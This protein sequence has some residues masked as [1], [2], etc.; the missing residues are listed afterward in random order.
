M[1]TNINFENILGNQANMGIVISKP[2]CT[3]TDA[4]AFL[5]A[6]AIT[7]RTITNAICSLVVG[8]KADGIWSKFTAIYPFVGGTASTHKWNL[9]D[10]RDLN[11]AYRLTFNGGWTHDSQ[12]VK[13]NGTNTYADT[14]FTGTLGMI[15]VYMPRDGGPA[16]GYT[17][18]QEYCD[19]G[20]YVNQQQVCNLY[21]NSAQFSSYANYYAYGYFGE[22]LGQIGSTTGYKNGVVISGANGS[23]PVINLP[24]GAIRA[25][26]YDIYGSIYYNEVYAFNNEVQSFS[27]F[28]TVE[29][30]ATESANLYT[31]V[32]A[33]QTA[34]GRQVANIPVS[35]PDAF[36]FL[37]NGGIRNPGT[38]LIQM[39]ALENLAI[40]LKTAN[41]WTKMRDIFPFLTD[42]RN[43]FS[44]SQD[45]ANAYW[46]KSNVAIIANST[47]APNN[48]TTASSFLETANPSNH[49]I[50]VS[51]GLTLSAEKY[52]TSIYLKKGT[53]DWAYISMFNVVTSDTF[54]GYFNL[55]TGTIGTVTSGATATIIDSGNGWYRCTLTRTMSTYNGTDAC[56]IGSASADNTPNYSGSG[57]AVAMYIWGAQL[58]FG[59]DA[60][61][62]QVITITSSIRIQS[63][64]GGNLKDQNAPLNGFQGGWTFSRTG[65]KGNGINGYVQPQRNFTGTFASGNVH[66]SIYSRVGIIPDRLM[67]LWGASIPFNPYGTLQA[68]FMNVAEQYYSPYNMQMSLGGFGAAT[69]QMLNTKGLIMTSATNAGT[70]GARTYQNGALRR[71]DFAGTGLP[72]NV[73]FNAYYDYNY[74]NSK[75]APFEIAFISTGLGLTEAEATTFNTIVANYQTALSRQADLSNVAPVN[76]AAPVLSGTPLVG[77]TLTSSTGTWT[78]AT[79]PN[80]YY[81]W[82]RNGG[83]D[84]GITTSTYVLTGSDFNTNITCKVT[85][86]SIDGFSSPVTSNSFLINQAATNTNTPFISGQQQVGSTLTATSGSWTG[87]TPITFAYQWKKNGSNIVG[88]TSTTYVLVAGDAGASTTIQCV[89][90]GTNS[91]GSGTGN[92]N[93][94]TNIAPAFPVN[95]I[96]PVISGTQRVGQ[97]LTTTNGTWTGIT[98]ITYT[99]QWK[100]NGSNI[101]SATAQTYTLVSGDFGTGTTIQCVVTGTNSFGN[102]T[103]NSN[104]LTGVG[105]ALPVV[106]DPN[107]QAFI[108]AADIPDVTQANAI[109][110]LVIG[111]KADNL[112]NSLDDIYPLVGGTAST[113]KWNLK[114]PTGNQLAFV[115]G[116]THDSNGITGNGINGF[117]YTNNFTARSYGVYSRTANPTGTFIGKQRYTSGEEETY[118]W[119]YS[120]LFSDGFQGGPY[121]VY[122]NFG[123]TA[124]YDNYYSIVGGDTGAVNE[125]KLYRK[126][127]NILPTAPGNLTPWY[128]DTPFAL[129]ATNIRYYFWWDTSQYGEYQSYVSNANIAFAHF[130]TTLLNAT[131]NANLYNRIKTFQQALG[132]AVFEADPDAQAFITAAAIT[133]TTQQTAVNNLVVGLKADGLWTKMKAIYPFVGGTASS[134]KFNLKD[135]RDLDAAF[136]LQFFGGVTHNA[137][138]MTGNGTNGYANT[139]VKLTDGVSALGIPRGA[140]HWSSYN[141]SLP[142]APSTGQQTGMVDANNTSNFFGWGVSVGQWYFG[143]QAF[144]ATGVTAATGFLMLYTENFSG[145]VYSYFNLNG[146]SL[147]NAGYGFSNNWSL[148]SPYFFLGTLGIPSGSPTFNNTN[149]AFVSLGDT[150]NTAGDITNFNTRVQAFQ[151]TLG[152]LALDADAQAFVTAANITNTTQIIAIDNLVRGLKVDGLWTK[153]AALYPFVGGTASSHKFNLKNPQ[154]TDGALRLQFF[155]GWTHDANGITGNGT[156]SYADTFARYSSNIYDGYPIKSE[157]NHWSTYQTTIGTIASSNGIQEPGFLFGFSTGY[158]TK[159]VGLQQYANT[160]LTESVAFWNGTVTSS[161]AGALYKNGTSVFTTSAAYG[162]SNNPTYV[163]GASRFN[164][165]ISGSNN[166]RFAF[167]SIGSSLTPTNAANFNTRVQAFQAALGRQV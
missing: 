38:S 62:Y 3:D 83:G 79:T 134:H 145:T 100:K 153:I 130:T 118:D 129:L 43:I 1:S 123:T 122:V 55:A 142:T 103:G 161:Q 10:P 87:N 2:T 14:Y 58:E 31:R 59:L 85:A 75:Y 12:G 140:N 116:I 125:L 126:G 119:S 73:L 120:M 99:Y 76:T 26:Y 115:G 147:G 155:G 135:P 132:R 35:D 41:I 157:N 15:G 111:L 166:A 65:A 16:Y 150:I 124:P 13:G 49:I 91:Y 8:L 98:P 148:A 108:N 96:A 167:A 68:T 67:S 40:G 128:T 149:Y 22:G 94:L 77:Q 137:N 80:F 4:I 66:I 144:Y 138:G 5:Q 117:A 72:F 27:Y 151:S 52:T 63:Q 156:N 143:G 112:W 158:S 56:T 9:K 70:N 54:Y 89:V 11:A 90:T 6:A 101:V 121:G 64:F 84:T 97:V 69:L 51:S 131:Q 162:I 60:T 139:F 113:H 160:G 136:R 25:I 106:S 34:L 107:A 152:R 18:A 28:S 71:I 45:F 92:S 17:Q 88:A 127:I 86:I 57:G 102:G 81:R 133:D 110:N 114:S 163:I 29:L 37:N 109:N 78:S 95:T 24:L 164:G 105:A 104:I 30:N 146:T 42:T 33:F 20:C 23:V 50:Y 19:E 36:R 61:S 21:S 141:R 7:D 93:I 32:Q 74:G 47:S 154:D 44:Y 82:Y 159:Y 48:T 46:N 39:T 165:N 53:R